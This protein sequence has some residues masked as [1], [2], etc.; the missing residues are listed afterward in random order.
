MIGLIGKGYIY[1]KIYRQTN[2]ILLFVELPYI[3][4]VGSY[5]ITI[6]IY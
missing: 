1:L 3:E 6:Y 2:N 5:F 4:N